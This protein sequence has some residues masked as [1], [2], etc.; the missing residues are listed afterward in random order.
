MISQTTKTII[1]FVV[2]GLIVLIGTILLV[3]LARGWRVNIFPWGVRET[4]LVLINSEPNG[5]DITINDK[6]TKFK[7]PY[8]LTDVN[9]GPITIGMKKT[10]FRDWQKKATVYPGEVTFADYAW[11]IPNILKTEAAA[12]DLNPLSMMTDNASKKVAFTA[13]KPTYSIWLKNDLAAEPQNIYTPPLDPNYPLTSIGL[14]GFN[15]DNSQILTRINNTLTG[16][17][18]IVPIAKSRPAV[19]FNTTFGVNPDLI[20]FSPNNPNELVITDKQMLRKANLDSKTL[21]SVIDDGVVTYE[22][23]RDKIYYIRVT[24]TTRELWMA[25]INSFNKT[26]LAENLEVSANYQLKYSRYNDKESLALLIRDNGNLFI[27]SSL[28]DNPKSE[29]INDSASNF[30]FSKNGRYLVINN[31]NKLVS[32]DME[33][34]RRA[35]FQTSLTGLSNWAWANDQHLVVITDKLI[36]LMDYDGQNDQMLAGNSRVGSGLVFGADKTIGL[37]TES[38]SSQNALTTIHLMDK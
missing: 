28:G 2:G 4:G 29:L 7:S 18:W 15:S 23:G 38:F 24:K 27:Y 26:K 37:L 35:E 9:P 14:N 1:K 16:H 5:A 36:R 25:D 10:G 11:L 6:T 3:A 30:I 32:V 12:T 22:I 34:G 19:N 31:D 20:V 17:H 13:A 8:R 33:Q 21:S